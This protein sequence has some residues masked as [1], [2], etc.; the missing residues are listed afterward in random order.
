MKFLN[1][2]S[3]KLEKL[4][5]MKFPEMLEV[6]GNEE[7]KAL[8]TRIILKDE[9]KDVAYELNLQAEYEKYSIYFRECVEQE[10]GNCSESTMKFISYLLLEILYPPPND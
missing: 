3:T 6:A 1:L 7:N 2:D 5:K 9:M 4:K 10:K 8:V